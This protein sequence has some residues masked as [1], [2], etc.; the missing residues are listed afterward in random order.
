[1][2]EGRNVTRPLDP[3]PEPSFVPNL[4]GSPYFEVFGLDKFKISKNIKH[5]N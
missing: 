2:E 3:R 4:L 1:M 5:K